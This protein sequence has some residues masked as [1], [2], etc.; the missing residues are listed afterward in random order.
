MAGLDQ[1][2]NVINE[3]IE[4]GL[5]E[6]KSGFV[7]DE[8]TRFTEMEKMLQWYNTMLRVLNEC[9]DIMDTSVVGITSDL[10]RTKQTVEV[11]I[12]CLTQNKVDIVA[13]Q[14]MIDNIQ[15][16]LQ[17]SSPPIQLA[18][19]TSSFPPALAPTLAPI[20]GAE[21]PNKDKAAQPKEDESQMD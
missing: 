8:E 11:H 12:G 6:I 7:L 2:L 21:E 16:Q 19:S 10:N 14:H 4:V 5:K 20:A 17:I 3:G 18:S 13:L 15:N 1:Q 9:M